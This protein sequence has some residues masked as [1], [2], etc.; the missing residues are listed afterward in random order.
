MS[1]DAISPRYTTS[2]R[3]RPPLVRAFLV[4]LVFAGRA[5]AAEPEAE[6]GPTLTWSGY[7]EAEGMLFLERP[8]YAGQ[9]RHDGSLA[10]SPQ[11]EARWEDGP[12]FVLNLFGRL[13]AADPHRTHADV[14]EAMLTVPG[15]GWEVGLGIGKVFWGV[16]ESVHLVDIV[17]QTDRVENIDLEEKLGQPMASV[18]LV[19]DFGTLEAFYLPWFREQRFPSTRGRLRTDPVVDDD[20]STVGRRTTPLRPD[21]ALRFSTTLE[22]WDVGL[23]YFNGTSR[24]PTLRPVLDRGGR[25]V[26]APEYERISQ[27]GIDVQHTSGPWLLKFEGIHR[28]GQKDRFG[29]ERSFTAFVAGAEYLLPQVFGSGIDVTLVGEYVRDSRRDASW[30]AF[31]NDLFLGARFALNDAAG[32]TG[33]ISLTQDLDTP[34]RLLNIEASRRLNDSMTVNLEARFFMNTRPKDLLNFIRRDDY[35]RLS[36]RQYF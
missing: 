21:V 33:K 30:S 8:A 32:T 18:K 9:R 10:L 12:R 3:S 14:R 29:I 23:S 31:E 19:R 25:L 27:W 16:A 20:L 1:G 34:S 35:V 6:A 22:A 2:G 13:D 7:A 24:E 15:D 11:M 36:L 28:R 17:N 4:S 5:L 26:F